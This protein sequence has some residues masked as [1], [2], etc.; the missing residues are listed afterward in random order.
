MKFGL[1]VSAFVL[2]GACAPAAQ[3]APQ[4]QRQYKPIYVPD[5]DDAPAPSVAPPPASIPAPAPR[6]PTYKPEPVRASAPTSPPPRAAA[7]ETI[8]SPPPPRAPVVQPAPVRPPEPVY[9]PPPPRPAPTPVYTPTPLAGA[10]VAPPP[11]PVVSSANVIK[12]AAYL[13]ARN[14]QTRTCAG[15]PVR[16]F[17]RGPSTIA[18]VRQAYGAET[19][20]FARRTT[21]EPQ[22][23]DP[24]VTVQACDA[25]GGFAFDRLPDGEYYVAA[26]VSIESQAP[27]GTY[28]IQEGGTIV[29]LVSVSGGGVKPVVLTR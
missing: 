16:L 26:V 7:P 25:Q 20:G 18:Y 9:S 10:P 6:A 15:A 12:G 14:G 29:S 19:G 8:Y 27:S 24:V 17:P 23:F 2:I 28:V 13:R 4:A 21:W 5:D 11:A 3:A 1:V 22:P